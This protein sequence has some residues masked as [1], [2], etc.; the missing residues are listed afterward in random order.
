MGAICNKIC[1]VLELFLIRPETGRWTLRW[2]LALFGFH[3][4]AIHS[5]G[6]QQCLAYLLF[7]GS[8]RSSGEKKQSPTLYSGN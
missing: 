6:L 7:S 2:S 3:L 1:L 8:L 5:F 4:C